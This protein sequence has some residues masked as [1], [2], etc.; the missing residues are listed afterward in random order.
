MKVVGKVEE[1]PPSPQ[2]PDTREKEG[3]S[4]DPPKKEPADRGLMREFERVWLIY[5]RRV[6]KQE[7]A[8]AWKKARQVAEYEEIEAG[9]RRYAALRQGE[10]QQYT[11]HFSRWLNARAW[12]DE[13]GVPHVKQS[14]HIDHAAR[15]ADGLDTLA[16]AALDFDERQGNRGPF[17]AA[18]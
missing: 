18:H 2:R 15:H 14:G 16:R 1:Q 5:P 4:I 7:A 10:D 9:V 17:E 12:L 13:P 6:D 11:K 8:K 3:G